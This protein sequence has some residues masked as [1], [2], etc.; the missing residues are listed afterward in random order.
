MFS[1]CTILV[2]NKLFLY[3]HVSHPFPVR[4]HNIYAS[5]TDGMRHALSAALCSLCEE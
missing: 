5:L 4:V 3:I 1:L 2:A